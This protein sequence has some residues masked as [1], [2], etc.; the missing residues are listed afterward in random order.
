[1][2]ETT[3]IAVGEPDPTANTYQPVSS[4]G[5]L[6]IDALAPWMTLALA[7][8]CDALG[9]MLSPLHDI[10]ADTG[11]DGDPDYLP[12][13]GMLLDPSSCPA[14]D[15][16]YLAQFAGV[17]LPDGIGADQARSLILN[18]PA[19]KRGGP[20]AIIAAAKRFLIGTQSVTLIE[21]HG[22]NGPDAYWFMLV[23]RPEELGGAV[24]W[25]QEDLPWSSAT[26]T[27]NAGDPV[28]ALTAAVN[29]AKPA[30]VKWQLVQSDGTT[31]SAATGVWSAETATWVQAADSAN[32]V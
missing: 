28:A 31:W 7:W 6:L 2:P 26:G 8:Y 19:R 16:P 17:Q 29:A 22:P 25:Q 4:V 32:A 1:M 21:R 23:V 13:Y 11:F 15:L 5:A 20:D 9:V 30:G 18:E 10:V 14:E 27:W 12:G 24:T 3:V